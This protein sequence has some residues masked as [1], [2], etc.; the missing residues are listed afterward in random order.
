MKK[1]KLS[2]AVTQRL[3][4]LLTAKSELEKSLAY[5]YQVKIQVEQRLKNSVATLEAT[6]LELSELSNSLEKEYG[7]ASEFNIETGEI[8]PSGVFE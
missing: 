8:V 1:K 6:Q 5:D 2:K 4:D 7:K 3:R